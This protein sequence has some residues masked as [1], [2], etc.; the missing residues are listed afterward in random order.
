MGV[1]FR[2]KT[3]TYKP[4][5]WTPQAINCYVRGGVCKGCPYKV[6]LESIDRC[7]TKQAVIEL[8][9]LYGRPSENQLLEQIGLKRCAM[10]GKIKRLDKDYHIYEYTHCIE[11]TKIRDA[12][13]RRKA[14]LKKGA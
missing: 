12:E 3:T 14:K 5:R 6:E 8:V 2:P 10:C 1:M 7:Y 9:R 4:V 13:Y 11:C